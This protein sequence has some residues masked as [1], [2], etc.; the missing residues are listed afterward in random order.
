MIKCVRH[1]RNRREIANER[2]EYY[3]IRTHLS[4]SGTKI[5][6]LSED[7]EKHHG[8]VESCHDEKIENAVLEHCSHQL[9]HT[10]LAVVSF[11]FQDEDYKADEGH[12]VCKDVRFEDTCE[13]ADNKYLRRRPA[14]CRS[15]GRS[16]SQ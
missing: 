6:Y 9:R 13:A 4:T 15:T 7:N 5:S 14:T 10:R 1:D 2:L 3:G 12:K 8:D 11:E 16:R